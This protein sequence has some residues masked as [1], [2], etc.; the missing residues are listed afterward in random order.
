MAFDQQTYVDEYKREH[1]DIIRATVPKG[2]RDEIK[3]A[4]TLKGLSVSQFIVEA[5]E[6]QYGLDLSK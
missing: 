1:Y 5:L 6:R 2:K 3:Q 4:A